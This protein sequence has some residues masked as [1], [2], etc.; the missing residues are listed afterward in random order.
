MNYFL[1]S[2]TVVDAGHELDGQRVSLRIAH[3]SIDAIGEVGTLAAQADEQVLSLPESACVSPG[4]IDL[5]AHLQDPGHEHKESMEALATAA[6]R[7][8]FTDL[9]CYPETDPPLDRA[10]LIDGLQRRA[11]R[12]PAQLHFVG[13]L[14]EQGHGAE[15]AELY[16]MHRVGA[17]AFTNGLQ[18]LRD[19]GVMLRL[20]QYLRAFDGLMMLSPLET[21]LVP[22][23][24]MNE[25]P[26]AVRLGM[27]GIPE[28]AESMAVAQD[29]ELLH[30]APGRLHYQ[31]LTSPRALA[32]IVQAR[33]HASQPLTMGVPLC[34]LIHSDE[35]L[36]SFDTRL[37]V[38]PPLRSPEQRAALRAALQRGE[39]DVLT[40]GHRAQGLEEKDLEFALAEP[41]MLTLQTFYPLAMTLVQ[42][43]LLSTSDLIA[44]ITHGPR[45]VLGWPELH[46][47]AGADAHLTLFDPT[48]HWT[49]IAQDIP[50]RAK[51]SPYLGQPL[52]GQVLG[53]F[54]QG[55]WI[56]G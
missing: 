50:S 23:G 32:Q 38:F 22:D 24:Q 49:L 40:S 27:R 11:A 51:N 5:Q 33:P 13:H 17:P 55:Q 16:D 56:E 2:V 46:L 44:L 14:T 6:A 47:T 15:L 1:P 45:R 52:T 9:I 41:G 42:D 18:R 28:V 31:P 20:L 21:R 48:A 54:C 37:K 26:Q 30:Y 3:G 19:S 34:Y 4:W 39:I 12:L 53:T 35:E 29:L 8:G 36:S 25:S 10:Q 7:G 43:R